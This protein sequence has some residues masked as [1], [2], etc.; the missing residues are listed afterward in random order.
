MWIFQQHNGVAYH[1]LSSSSPSFVRSI[2]SVVTWTAR[3]FHTP[4]LTFAVYRELSISA[5]LYLNNPHTFVAI[6]YPDHLRGRIVGA[7]MSGEYEN[8]W[9]C[10]VAN[11]S[12]A[13][14]C[15]ES[16]KSLSVQL[17]RDD[18]SLLC[19]WNNRDIYII[20][21]AKTLWNLW[22]CVKLCHSRGKV[23]YVYKL[24]IVLGYYSLFLT[25]TQE[26]QYIFLSSLLKR[27]FER[28]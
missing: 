21:V 11:V 16:L 22:M 4:G 24:M 27:V 23:K 25:F 8:S 12:L 28:L 7:F 15:R 5:T 10:W 20:R 3:T 9:N 17:L 2:V 1:C 14:T 26:M 6:H 19:V 18:Q 13:S